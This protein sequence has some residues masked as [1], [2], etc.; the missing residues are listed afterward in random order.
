M[1][2]GEDPQRRAGLKR[3]DK[4]IIP[5]RHCIGCANGNV[6]FVVSHEQALL[7]CSS[8]LDKKFPGI[9]IRKVESTEAGARIVSKSKKGI[10]IATLDT[11]KHYGL[12][13]V[14]EDIVPDNHSE[15]WVLERFN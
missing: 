1:Q 6:D 15:F 3:V 14:E 5:I 11:C 4:V 13:I 12:T 9:E 2:P 7:Q 10:A 8:Y